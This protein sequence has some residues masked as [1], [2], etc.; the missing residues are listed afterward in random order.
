MQVESCFIAQFP[1]HQHRKRYIYS[2]VHSHK[3]FQLLKIYLYF[4]S[5][6]NNI[7]L[8]CFLNIKLMVSEFT[9]YTI[10]A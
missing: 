8:K 3:K 5:K 1:Y 2:S 4:H 6:F 9:D 10:M 7:L